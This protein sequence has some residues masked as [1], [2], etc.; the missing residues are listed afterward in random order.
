MKYIKRCYGCGEIIWPWQ[1]RIK[2]QKVGFIHK[3]RGCIL[4]A[5]YSLLEE[6]AGHH[7]PDM[8]LKEALDALQGGNK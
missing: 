4:D 2:T 7:H 8:L 1:G 5:W 6:K 3:T